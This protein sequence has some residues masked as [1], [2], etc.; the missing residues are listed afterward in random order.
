MLKQLT[1]PGELLQHQQQSPLQQVSLVT[2]A[3]QL[4]QPGPGAVPA[5]L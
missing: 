1:F 4:H 5:L 2:P 3:A